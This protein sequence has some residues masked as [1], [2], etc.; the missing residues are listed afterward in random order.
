ML[1]SQT[2]LRGTDTLQEIVRA[3]AQMG[4]T[5]EQVADDLRRENVRGL[6][7]ST[8]FL[9]PVVRRLN[10]TLVIGGRL[11]LNADGTTLRLYRGGRVLDATLPEAVR[12]F[13]AAFHRGGYPDLEVPR[14]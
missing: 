2:S 12:R 11:E 7:D 4:D 14:A 5:S 1:M 3:L 13:L 6:R 8:S 9:N 10:S